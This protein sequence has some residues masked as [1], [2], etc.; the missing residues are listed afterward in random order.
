MSEESLFLVPVTLPVRIEGGENCVFLNGRFLTNFGHLSLIAA[1]PCG[2]T[3]FWG[4][5]MGRPPAHF[6][7]LELTG[8]KKGFPYAKRCTLIQLSM[9]IRRLYIFSMG[10]ENLLRIKM[11]S[12]YPLRQLAFT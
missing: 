12:T 3:L 11:V 10:N 8:T 1:I 9:W 5:E 6:G 7:D 2:F 4:V